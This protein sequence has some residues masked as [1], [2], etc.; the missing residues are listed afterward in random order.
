MTSKPQ[1]PTVARW[2]L[3]REL[4]RLR[5]DRKPADVVRPLRAQQTSLARWEDGGPGGQVPGVARLEGLLRVYEVGDEEAARLM[6]LRE[7]ARTPGW[8]QGHDV[9]KPYG[10]F[11][12]LEDSAAEIL[13]YEA[14]LIP[15]LLQTERYTHA[16]MLAAHA[17]SRA[18]MTD[19]EDRV[20]VRQ[21][22]QSRWLERQT[23]HLWAVVGEAALRTLVGGSDIMAEQ[24]RHLLKMAE[25]QD[26]LTLQV[27][28][29][30]AGAHSATEL[31]SF[32]I[33]TVNSEGLS[34]VYLEGPT[35]DMF[36]DDPADVETYRRVFEHLRKAA[37]NTP[38]SR[39]LM[40]DI[41]EGLTS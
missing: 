33:L 28:P 10:T 30:A 40:I 37:L 18:P 20:A 3:A 12:G 31:N 2:V 8:W 4:R 7:V 6:Q 17:P 35:A 41:L 26:I 23:P 14:Q 25:R 29:F 21:R 39:A 11:I 22:R 32:A 19:I 13:A 1:A 9:E 15:G 24:L 5:G 34:T 16:V 27:L 38:E 36:M